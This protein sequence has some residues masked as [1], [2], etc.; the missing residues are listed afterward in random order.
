MFGLRSGGN[1]N[2]IWSNFVQG[3]NT[4]YSSRKLR[5]HDFFADQYKSFFKLDGD[6]PLKILEIGCGPGALAG[7]LH[8]WY[9]NAEITAIDR[10]SEFIRFASENEQGIRFME[11]DATALP[12]GDNTFDVTISNTVSEHI[13]PSKFYGEQ[14]RI[15]KSGGVCINLSSRKGIC[16]TPDCLLESEL[17]K[18]FW[19]E[20]SQYDDT[21]EKYSV[22]KY[23]MSE[24]ELF[25]EM[26]F[27]GFESVTTAYATVDLT[28]DDPKFPRDMAREMINSLRFDS[29]D[30]LK[31]VKLSMPERVSDELIDEI[32]K[33]VN[34]RYD[35]RIRD[36][37][38]GVKHWETNLSIIMMVR[39]VKP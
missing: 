14:M 15:L 17:E 20:M 8:R 27:R 22:C 2:V 4:L 24:S 33:A 34:L 39:G 1:M 10:D 7:A 29:L 28:P 16:R 5:F 36:L 19:S 23:P 37:E 18:N 12:F 13:E 38:R 26:N 9:P 11:G 30:S 32:E 21:F 31:S 3:I 25:R 6:K 35:A